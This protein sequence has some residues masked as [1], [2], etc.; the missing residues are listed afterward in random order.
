V[1]EEVQTPF[2]VAFVKIEVEPTHTSFAPAIAAT[3][4]SA[5]TVTVTGADVA[6]QPLAFVAVTV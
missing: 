1:F 3:T 2:A 6:V 5:F 4:G